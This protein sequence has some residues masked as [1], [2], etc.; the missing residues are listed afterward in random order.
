MRKQ[1]LALFLGLLTTGIFAQKNELKT[2]ER[3]IKKLD[4]ASAASAIKSAEALLSNMDDKLKAKFYFL[5]GKVLSTKK[6]FKGALDA[7][8]SLTDLENKTGRKK[9]SS[10]AV[11]IKKQ[12]LTE[13]SKRGIK[14][15]K[16]KDYKGAV[17][18]FY[19]TFVLSPTDTSFLSN[20]ALAAFNGKDFDTSLKH[21]IKLKELGYTGI[22]EMYF[23]KDKETGVD[24]KFNSKTERSLY[25]KS[26]QYNQPR[27]EK[28]KSK[29]GEIIERIALIY[30]YKE[31]YD[32][33]IKEIQLARQENPENVDLIINEANFYLKLGKKDKYGE[34]IKVAAEKNPTN[35]E[36]FFS[37]GLV[38][39]DQGKKED[40]EKYFKKAIEIKPDYADAYNSMYALIITEEEVIN[41][42]M[43]GLTDFDKYDELEAKKKVIYKKA[44]PYLE[45]SD[46]LNRT[47]NT[48]K[49]LRSLYEILGMTEKAKEFADIQK[50]M[51]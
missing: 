36:L 10:Q 25:L 20:A 40:A 21:Y 13:V 22:T 31:D 15:F 43:E 32:K 11:D 49:V 6:D 26:G 7:I 46:E 3:A 38:S 29:K 8:T 9:Y 16:A 48:V 44:L 50:K 34:L 2:A 17:E 51:G 5:K 27:S 35:A 28:T 4:Y 1:V 39:R 12:M 14:K 19:M 18:D 47:E 24:K 37:L 33:A 30:Y 41:K 42:Q 23:A 45:K